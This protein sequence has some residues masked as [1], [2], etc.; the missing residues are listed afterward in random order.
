MYP[1]FQSLLN[2]YDI[3]CFAETKIDDI[4]EINCDHFSFHY[5]NRKH[6]STHRS[7]CVALGFRDNLKNVIRPINTDCPFV[8]WFKVHGKK[9]NHPMMLILVLLTFHPKITG[10]HSISADLENELMV[11]LKIYS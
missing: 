4:D 2:N 9:I 7:E 3:V 11:Y 10:V 8:F 1:E 6:L 5:K